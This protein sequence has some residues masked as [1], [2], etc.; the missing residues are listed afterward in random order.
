MQKEILKKQ[1]RQL[2]EDV[3]RKGNISKWFCEAYPI[4]EENVTTQYLKDW[5]WTVNNLYKNEIE[6]NLEDIRQY[7]IRKESK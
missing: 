6:E 4:K 2:K 3:Q 7:F 5:I 1:A